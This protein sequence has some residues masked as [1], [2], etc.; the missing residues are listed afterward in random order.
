MVKID[1]FYKRWFASFNDL[2]HRSVDHIVT[3][4]KYA[5]LIEMFATQNSLNASM[6]T[7]LLISV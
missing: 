4:K 7:S 1:V 5:Q 3:P 6:H 2:I